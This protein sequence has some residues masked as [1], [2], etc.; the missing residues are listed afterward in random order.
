MATCGFTR[1][2]SF[3]E[4]NAFHHVPCHQLRARQGSWPRS[5]WRTNPWRWGRPRCRSRC[6]AS[7]CGWSSRRSCGGCCSRRGV[8]VAVGVG[9]AAAP[10]RSLDRNSR[11]RSGLEVADHR[12]C[13]LWRLIGVKPEIIKCTPANRIGVLILRKGFTVPSYGIGRL[14]HSPWSTAVT[15]VV[16]RAVICPAGL[17]RRRMKADVTYVDTWPQ[18]HTKRLDSSVQVLV[19]QG[20]LIVPE[21]WTW[22]GHFVSHKPDAI[23]AGIRFDLVYCHACPRQ[24]AGRIRTVEAR[25]E[26]EKLVVP[27]TLNWR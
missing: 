18:R 11:G 2:R 12:I 4:D 21:S 22:I 8:A 24:M 7:R 5:R 26:N 25:G 16:K 3:T 9:D 1:P 20:I 23:I 6:C 14:S 13:F 10:G 17:L 27:L 19:I 15:L